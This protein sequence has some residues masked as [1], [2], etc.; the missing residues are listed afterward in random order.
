MLIQIC[1]LFLLVGLGAHIRLLLSNHGWLEFIAETQR[2]HVNALNASIPFVQEHS[3]CYVLFLVLFLDILYT[4]SMATH[5]NPF[6]CNTVYRM[7]RQL[8]LSKTTNRLCF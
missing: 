6:H 8:Q 4:P 7:G 2:I 5:H 3:A 1:S